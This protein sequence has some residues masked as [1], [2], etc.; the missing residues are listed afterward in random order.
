VLRK[1]LEDAWGCPVYDNYGTHE[2]GHIAYECEAQDGRHVA[3]DTAYVE[4][5]D[6]ETGKP[7][8]FGEAGNMV[9][10]SLYRTAPL[11]IRYDLRD[12][13]KIYPRQQC[14][15]GLCSTKLSSFL[16]R[17]DEMVKLRGTNVYPMACQPAVREDPRLTGEFICVA[18]T[19]GEGLSARTE[20]AVRVERRSPEIDKAAIVSDLQA[21]LHKDLSVKVKVE[22]YEK[23]ELAPLIQIGSTGKT[24]RL[25]DL[26]TMK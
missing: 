21:R 15:C 22:V 11:M 7:L 2:V 5:Q 13:M 4:V 1:A 20:M 6:V 16:G 12:L 14:S 10:T 18:F 23:E 3:E 19:E 26:R 9:I 24:R 8:G 25:L 17:S